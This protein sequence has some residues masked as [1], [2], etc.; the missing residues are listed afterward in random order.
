MNPPQA[1]LLVDKNQARPVG[2][3]REDKEDEIHGYSSSSSHRSG[4]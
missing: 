3:S 2:L 1:R 4:G